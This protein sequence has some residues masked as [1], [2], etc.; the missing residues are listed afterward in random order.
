M[1]KLLVKCMNLQTQ[2]EL[3]LMTK[4]KT[5]YKQ[6]AQQYVDDPTKTKY[7][8][9]LKMREVFMERCSD[10]LYAKIQKVDKVP[11]W[12]DSEMSSPTKK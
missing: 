10:I 8:D 3:M 11:D 2:N 7:F 9:Q 12:H 5:M 4:S 6:Q 1:T